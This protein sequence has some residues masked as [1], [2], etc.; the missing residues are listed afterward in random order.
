MSIWTS[1][2]RGLRRGIVVGA[3]GEVALR[4]EKAFAVY[5][6]P[7][8][9]ALSCTAVAE[10][11]SF[12]GS[13]SAPLAAGRALQSE[14]GWLPLQLEMHRELKPSPKVL[15]YLGGDA[16]RIRDKINRGPARFALD[17]PSEG[18]IIPAHPLSIPD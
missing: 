8:C 5:V 1:S 11:G 16:R 13:P 4:A 17:S 3:S 15:V 14:K 7:S 12:I 18:S 9:N 6:F 10:F 2:G